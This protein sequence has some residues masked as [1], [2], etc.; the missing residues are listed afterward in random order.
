MTYKTSE[1]YRRLRSMIDPKQTTWGL[2]ANDVKAIAWAIDAIDV[3]AAR[4]KANHPPMFA[5]VS[6]KSCGC[7]DTMMTIDF[8]LKTFSVDGMN[9]MIGKGIIRPVGVDEFNS[10]KMKCDSC[11]RK[12]VAACTGDE[13]KR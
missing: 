3:F 1:N 10:L 7:I 5:Y 2:S 9:E 13:D 4:A 12:D 6:Q 8:A 11:Y